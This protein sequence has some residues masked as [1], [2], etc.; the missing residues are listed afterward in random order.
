MIVQS[1]VIGEFI[2]GITFYYV[3]WQIDPIGNSVGNKALLDDVNDTNSSNMAMT[4]PIS[5]HRI[6]TT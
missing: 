2:Q 5:M 3:I 1:E 4:V 6:A